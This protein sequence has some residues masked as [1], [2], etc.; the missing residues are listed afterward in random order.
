MIFNKKIKERIWVGSNAWGPE[1]SV[2]RLPK[3]Q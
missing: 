2:R 1:F 3:A